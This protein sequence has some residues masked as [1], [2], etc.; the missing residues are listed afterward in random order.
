MHRLA[1]G[2][3]SLDQVI[4]VSQSALLC[5]SIDHIACLAPYPALSHAHRGYRTSLAARPQV[6]T[7][8]GGCIQCNPRRDAQAPLPGPRTHS[9]SFPATCAPCAQIPTRRPARNA[10]HAPR[11]RPRHSAF[12]THERDRHNTGHAGLSACLLAVLVFVAAFTHAGTPR[13]ALPCP[14]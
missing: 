4:V 9:A 5:A 3:D 7:H 1:L 2:R 12:P 8:Q 10:H 14:S 6:A 11:N 13:T